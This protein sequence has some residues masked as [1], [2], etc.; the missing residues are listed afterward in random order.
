MPDQEAQRNL[1]TELTKDGI[2]QL[3]APGNGT[4]FILQIIKITEDY[5]ENRM[6][7]SSHSGANYQMDTATSHVCFR[8]SPR[9]KI[10]EVN[11]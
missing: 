11:L 2:R 3:F 6:Y 10:S 4:E 9:K 8:G 5:S 7:L 1:P